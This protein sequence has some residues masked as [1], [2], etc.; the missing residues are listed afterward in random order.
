[1]HMCAECE[2]RKRPVSG[3]LNVPLHFATV[4]LFIGQSRA[5]LALNI[6]HR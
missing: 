1:M 2:C 5:F 4:K 3:E 6:P